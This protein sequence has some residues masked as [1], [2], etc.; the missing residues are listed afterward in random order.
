LTVPGF[1]GLRVVSCMDAL[2]TMLIKKI[3]A[4]FIISALAVGVA[5][6]F[7]ACAP[8]VKIP[9]TP[10]PEPS[11]SADELYIQGV[12]LFQEKALEQA[13]ILFN[14]YLTRFPAGAMADAALMKVGAIHAE[15]GNHPAARSIYEHLIDK[16][17]ASG[18]VPDARVE[19][20][21]G[22]F[23]EG[24]Y[25]EVVSGFAEIEKEPLTQDQAQRVLLL[26][27]D[28]HWITGS[29]AKAAFYY[30]AAYL[31]AP[32]GEQEAMRSKISEALRLLSPP[33]ITSLISRTVDPSA[34]SLLEEVARPFAFH[35]FSLGCLLPLSGRYASYGNRA[36]RG[37]ELALAR[38]AGERNLPDF[39]IIVKDTGGDPE[40]AARAVRELV[41]EHHVA[42][43]VGSIITAETA[44]LE[45]QRAGLPIITMTQKDQ[46]TQ[47]G[48]YVFRN[49]FTPGMQVQ[50]LV[51]YCTEVLGL[52][53]F[54]LLYPDE[55]Y[56]NKFMNL[57]WDE[58]IDAGGTVVAVEAYEPTQTDF[59]DSIKK[60]VGLYYEIPEDLKALRSP[61]AGDAPF[62][63]SALDTIL[64]DPAG[65]WVGSTTGDPELWLEAGNQENQLEA[66][67]KP[68]ESEE[69]K[70]IVDFE[71]I[72]IPD[73]PRKAGLIIP[74]LAYYDVKETYLLGTNLWFS[75][76]LIDMTRQYAQGAV[77]PVGFFPRSASDRVKKFV[78]VFRDTYGEEPGF[79]EAVAYDTAMMLLLAAGNPGTESRDLLKDT[80]LNSG[81]YEGVTGPTS[82][83]HDGD[84][85]K[86]L[87]LVRIKGR[88]FVELETEPSE[89]LPER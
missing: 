2:R 5:L 58:V 55:H 26:V 4:N 30:A 87:R 36:L 54:A 61:P 70:A 80:L 17:P 3:A 7:W 21:A 76:N 62:P 20:L 53:R 1:S 46:I 72:F 51:S 45:A 48:N 83:D 41:D 38:F 78:A 63:G 10:E 65:T 67:G 15:M 60:L 14:Q 71:A 44:A 12:R 27:G 57:F 77:I 47:I 22:Y 42:A 73:A 59:A 86:K 82:F 8:K 50:S 24:K 89:N 34:K 43:A 40:K 6:A 35:R 32:V 16:Y 68:E 13:L 69:P 18:F 28:A 11:I 9:K 29:P 33:E 79:I 37:V 66:A 81:I 49:F 64:M 25:E 31:N 88:E 56:G 19:I 23:Q 84:V 39:K 74:Q 52:E 85:I 75:Q